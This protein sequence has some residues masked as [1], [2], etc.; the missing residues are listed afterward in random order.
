M[1]EPIVVNAHWFTVSDVEDPDIYW[2]V[3]HF[4]AA[5]PIFEWQK[6]EAGQ[7]M[8]KYSDPAPSWHQATDLAS[9]GVRFLTRGYLTPELYTFWKL[10][11][12]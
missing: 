4:R 6:S 11:F 8:M 2:N 12:E 7:W 10:K 9:W 1:T 5:E 3:F